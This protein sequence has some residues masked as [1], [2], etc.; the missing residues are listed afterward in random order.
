MAQLVA[1]W[2][3]NPEAGGSNPSRVILISSF[4]L[5]ICVGAFRDA[6]TENVKDTKGING[7]NCENGIYLYGIVGIDGINRERLIK[8]NRKIN[9][10]D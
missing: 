2:I 9:S 6:G 5:S 4:L 3:P 1:R 7:P 10:R 8:E